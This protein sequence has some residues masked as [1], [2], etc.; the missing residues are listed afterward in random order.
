[1][2]PAKNS[3]A[4]CRILSVDDH[5]LM[6]HGIAQLL[7]GEA[8][9]MVCG[10]ADSAPR[11]LSAVRSLKPDLVL[12]DLTMPGVNGLELIKQMRAMH[13]EVAVLV[14]S[15]HDETLY[16]ERVLCAGGRGYIMKQEGG[17]KL[18]QAIRHVRSG[19]VYVSERVNAQVLEKLTGKPGPV[20]PPGIGQLTDRELEV[21]R[22]IG[23]AR[24]ARQIARELGMSRKTVEAHRLS[25][26]RKLKLRSGPEL[27]RYAVLWV[28]SGN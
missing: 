7:R 4:A 20:H 3:K 28:E 24:E 22:L 16:A 27:T 14:V 2:K 6:R 8:D 5:P 10:E 18:I 23:Q 25:I 13:P 17:G 12:A 1:M 11:A 21:L 19:R 15:M 9:L 26:K